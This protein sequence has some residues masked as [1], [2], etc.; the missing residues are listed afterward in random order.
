MSNRLTKGRARVGEVAASAAIQAG[1]PGFTTASVALRVA[2]IPITTLTGA[3]EVDTGY[4][5]PLN[6][7]VKNVMVEVKTREQTGS[8]KSISVGILTTQG[9]VTAQFLDLAS[10]A[11]VQCV[12]GS[13]IAGSVT[14]GSG[15][16]EGTAASGIF[17]KNFVV[18]GSGAL[19]IAYNLASAHTELVADIVVE[20]LQIA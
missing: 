18:A 12:Q 3:A 20:Y 4:A 16:R 17:P 6:S 5:L 13:L 11:S 15:L 1:S 10:T 8:T 7:V 19:N 14:R 2:R 9:G